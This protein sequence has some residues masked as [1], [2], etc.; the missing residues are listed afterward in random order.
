M[1]N[2]LIFGG[3]TEGRELAEI[4]SARGEKVTV[5]V[6]TAYGASMLRRSDFIKIHVGRL[7]ISEMREFIKANG[8]NLIID[9][10]HPYA[11]EVTKNI[12]L[13]MENL[14]LP[15][16]RLLREKSQKEDFTYVKSPA[17]VVSL[18]LEENILLTTGSKE[19]KSFVHIPNFQNAVYARVL[20]T[21]QAI[22]AC[23][24]AGLS[25]DHILA[26]KPPFS[27]EDN[28]KI[29]DDFKIKTIITKDGGENGG[30]PEKIKAAKNKGISLVVI[31]RPTSDSGYSFEEITK[32]LFKE[33]I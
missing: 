10:T 31:E 33:D 6:A 4:F 3:T 16:M 19:I 20:P 17:E 9:A 5:S 18:K 1:K 12:K 13:A 22:D 28:E 25:N 14:N 29:I 26:L 15:Y 27:C 23:V 2:V 7:G 8:F 32:L 30:F 24:M 21:E 11:V